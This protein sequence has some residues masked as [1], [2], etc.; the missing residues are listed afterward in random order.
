MIFAGP[1]ANFPPRFFFDKELPPDC[2]FATFANPPPTLFRDGAPLLPVFSTLS[3][4][5][6]GTL[7][8]WGP[9]LPLPGAVSSPTNPVPRARPFFML[10]SPSLG[11]PPP[12]FSFEYISHLPI[13]A[14]APPVPRPLSHPHI[15]DFFSLGPSFFPP[16]P[17]KS[18]QHLPYTAS[19]QHTSSPVF[20]L[21]LFLSA[22]PTQ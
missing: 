19:R 9:H 16:P 7:T 15:H 13:W 1:L 10:V 8:Q 2:P 6:P 20:Y 4:R 5:L 12:D 14:P 3:I 11:P 18:Y 21:L 22:V 17:G